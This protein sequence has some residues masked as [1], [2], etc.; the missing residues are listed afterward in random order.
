MFGF[1]R[2]KQKEEETDKPAPSSEYIPDHTFNYDNLNAQMDEIDISCIDPDASFEAK[3]G[4]T[5]KNMNG[6]S[7]TELDKRLHPEKYM[8]LEIQKI[9]EEEKALIEAEEKRDGK[10]LD[11]QTWELLQKER[12]ERK[13]KKIEACREKWMGMKGV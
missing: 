10:P 8:E 5:D 7:D 13:A 4:K 3:N 2:K 12:E 1:F 11:I 6:I 9:E